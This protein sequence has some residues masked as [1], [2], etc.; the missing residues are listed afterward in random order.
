MKTI[1]FRQLRQYR[2][3]LSS[4]I[5][6]KKVFFPVRNC[7]PVCC[8]SAFCFLVT[9]QRENVVFTGK[10]DHFFQIMMKCRR[11]SFV[12]SSDLFLVG[13]L[14][15]E[16]RV[17][18][19]SPPPPQQQ[20][21]FMPTFAEIISPFIPTTSQH[22]SFFPHFAFSLQPKPVAAWSLSVSTHSH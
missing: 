18:I 8:Q 7:L 12:R 15:H 22:G 14:S 10:K 1:H 2:S 17:Y 20:Q 11:Q 5:G 4:N 19:M 9:I 6:E 16:L 21:L 13:N 3:T